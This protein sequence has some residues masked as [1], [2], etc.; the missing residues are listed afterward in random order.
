MKPQAKRFSL[1]TKFIL[2]TVAS[3]AL[4]LAICA[5]SLAIYDRWSFNEH[6]KGELA[7]ECRIL[8]SNSAA[9][10]EFRDKDNAREVLSAVAADRRINVVVIYDKKG[11]ELV[12]YTRPKAILQFPPSMSKSDIQ[13]KGKF[14]SVSPVTYHG[15]FLG[16]I[17]LEGGEGDLSDRTRSYFLV[18]GLLMSIAVLVAVAVAFRLQKRIFDPI[19]QLVTGMG[20]ITQRKDYTV[21]IDDTGD[22]EVGRLVQTFN[23]MLYEIQ[24]RDNSLELR[25]DERTKALASEVSA[26][27]SLQETQIALEEAL[28]QANAAVEAKSLFLAKMSHEIR[29]P[30]NGVLG[31]TEILLGTQLDELQT[32]CA[33]TIEFSGRNLLEI[34]NDLLDFSKAEANKLILQSVPFGIEDLVSEVGAIMAPLATKKSLELACWCSPQVPVT[35]MGDPGRLRQILLNLIA[36]SVKFTDSGRVSLDVTVTQTLDSMVTLKFEV[37]DSGVGISDDQLSEIF[38]SFVQVDSGRTRKQ[39]GTG[40]GLTISKQLVELMGGSLDVASKLG[41]GSKFFFEIKCEAVTNSKPIAMLKG[42]KLL[43]GVSDAELKHRLMDLFQFHSV[44]T[45]A[46][47]TTQLVSQQIDQGSPLDFVILDTSLEVSDGLQVEDLLQQARNPLTSTYLLTDSSNIIPSSQAAHLG[48]SGVINK[49]FVAA[50]LLEMMIKSVKHDQK[51]PE[52]PTP[53]TFGSRTPHILLVEDNEVNVM[54]A[55]HFLST[56][57][58]T[59]TVAYNGEEAIS[60]FEV[61]SYDLVLM[62][63][64]LPVMDGLEATKRLR[65]SKEPSVR[66]VV[67]VAMTAN[68]F[69]SEMDACLEAGMNDYL[70]KPVSQADLSKML[71]KWLYVN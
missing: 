53:E 52:K 24:I 9:A 65:A 59:F 71:N 21:R 58:C 35:I 31:M 25:I 40:L 13:A 64:Q 48:L 51:H 28:K 34:I 62:D 56:L 3:T 23:E 27:R 6:L 41:Q 8:G 43:L 39:G 57:G 14:V 29:T 16:T 47:S 12:R 68:A 32:R 10:L 66:D 15:E 42:K 67:I 26:R 33:E 18:A 46:S 5:G 45:I 63:V 70:S 4:A 37:M 36:N 30:M 2:A 7:V 11:D 22:D 44:E 17:L 49:P 54:V 60:A 38:Q 20:E 1:R 69:A 61:G 19:A 50:N 55:S